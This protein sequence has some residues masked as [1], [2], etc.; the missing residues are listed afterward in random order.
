MFQLQLLI[1]LLDGGV[2]TPP[3]SHVGYRPLN[4]PVLGAVAV[5]SGCDEDAHCDDDADDEDHD[6]DNDIAVMMIITTAIMMI[7]VMM[8]M[9]IVTIVLLMV[10]TNV[11]RQALANDPII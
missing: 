10:E 1:D 4:T 9:V 5:G 7:V 3:T 2:L 8:M 6:D 11:F